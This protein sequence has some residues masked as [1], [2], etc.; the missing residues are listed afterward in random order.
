MRLSNEW[1]LLTAPP[2]QLLRLLPSVSSLAPAASHRLPVQVPRCFLIVSVQN[3]SAALE[4]RWNHQVYVLVFFCNSSSFSPLLLHIA[5]IREIEFIHNPGLA[6]P[7]HRAPETLFP[8]NSSRPSSL[9]KSRSWNPNNWSLKSA[10]VI[11]KNA[12]IT[13]RETRTSS[14]G[15]DLLTPGLIDPTVGRIGGG[16]EMIGEL[17][18]GVTEEEEIVDDLLAGDDAEE[19]DEALGRGAERKAEGV[20]RGGAGFE[21]GEVNI[22]VG[23]RGVVEAATGHGE[24]SSP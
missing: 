18:V 2:Q 6:S 7:G 24:G 10:M 12:A 11:S 5:P 8:A 23:V 16:N 4:H 3:P 9:L 1:I 21:D 17:C 20:A 13:R 14:P 19:V 22:G 15:V